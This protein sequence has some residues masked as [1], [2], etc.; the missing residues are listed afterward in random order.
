MKK[1]LTATT[2]AVA[3]VLAP[4]AATVAGA[5]DSPTPSAT[6][7]GHRPFR[8]AA[9]AAGVV[10]GAIGISRHDLVAALRSGKSVADV[11]KDHGVDPQAVV[12]ALVHAVDQRID[13][14]VT[15][16]RLDADRAA[17]LK[18]KVEARVT[19]L[20]GATKAQRVKARHHR[21]L[22][23]AV[24]RGAI[25]V[26]ARTIGVDAKTVVQARKN[27]HSIADLAREHNVDPQ[28]V[29]D[30]LVAAGTKK[31]DALVTKGKLDADKAASIKQQLPERAQKV[32]NTTGRARSTTTG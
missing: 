30:A 3:L 4:T 13:Q 18:D 32:V 24:R 27:G 2:V 25:A 19:K 7:D 28:K 1:L 11:A 12:D 9:Q 14:A 29:I 6:T 20:V 21:H 31:V 10:A 22:R 26:I 8:R 17:T 16:G 15:S 23:R 5:A